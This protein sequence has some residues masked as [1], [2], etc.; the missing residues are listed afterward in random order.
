[1]DLFAFIGFLLYWNKLYSPTPFEQRHNDRVMEL[2]GN[3]NPFID[4]PSW[5]GDIL[6]ALPQTA[7]F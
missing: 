3:R 4:N 7:N 2:R 6:L 1:M 5:A